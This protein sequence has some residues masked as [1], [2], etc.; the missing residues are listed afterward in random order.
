[1]DDALPDDIDTAAPDGP[2]PAPV[3]P[4]PRRRAMPGPPLESLGRTWIL[5]ALG[6]APGFQAERD[7][8]YDDVTIGGRVSTL[9]VNRVACALLLLNHDLRPDELARVVQGADRAELVDAVVGCLLPLDLPDDARTFT[10]WA[11]SALLANGLDPAKVPPAD[12]AAVLHQLVATGR[13]VTH[14]EFTAA[15]EFQ[16][17]RAKLVG[18]M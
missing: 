1:M 13:A 9:D 7:R 12:L 15:G 10:T 17:V 11:R 4:R 5:P 6:L 3:E 16:G 8:M 18:A 2:A 14:A